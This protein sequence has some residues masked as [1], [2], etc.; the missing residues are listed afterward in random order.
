MQ[1]DTMIML[2]FHRYLRNI[3]EQRYPL[4]GENYKA[5]EHLPEKK[6]SALFL[7][8]S[9]LTGR[10]ILQIVCVSVFS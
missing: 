3:R 4:T 7:Y 8:N 5:K 9:S 1:W 2:I 10:T 6:T